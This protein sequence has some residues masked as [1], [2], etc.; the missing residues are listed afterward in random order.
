MM[1]N[2]VETALKLTDIEEPLPSSSE[3]IRKSKRSKSGQNKNGSPLSKKMCQKKR[4]KN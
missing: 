3:I 4:K 2:D 1:M